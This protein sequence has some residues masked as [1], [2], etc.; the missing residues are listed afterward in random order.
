MKSEYIIVASLYS[1]G[2]FVLCI[3][4]NEAVAREL[5]IESVEAGEKNVRAYKG[6][7][8][9]RVVE[10]WPLTQ[11]EIAAL[12]PKE[13]ENLRRKRRRKS[14]DRCP[15]N[16]SAIPRSEWDEKSQACDTTLEQDA[17]AAAARNEAPPLVSPPETGPAEVAPPIP[18]TKEYLLTVRMRFEGID[19]VQARER[20]V[21]FITMHHLPTSAES[22]GCSIATKLQRLSKSGPPVKV[23]L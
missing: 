3:T 19:D 10:E 21:G 16:S 5:F 18:V 2:D 6:K 17:D 12:P 13:K 20:A 8:I 11:E 9:G 4:P 23:E 7:Q 22:D 15:R 1:G 14:W